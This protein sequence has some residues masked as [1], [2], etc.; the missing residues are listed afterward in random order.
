VYTG[1]RAGTLPSTADRR[2]IRLPAYTVADLGFYYIY[3]RYAFN[4][5]VGNVFDKRYYESAGFT[6]DL[7]IVPGA[8]RNIA[9][10]MRTHF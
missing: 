4:L 10:S 2:I 6:A 7:Q 3:G 8:P 9:L 5:K 1:E